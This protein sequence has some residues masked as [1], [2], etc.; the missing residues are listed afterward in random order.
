MEEDIDPQPAIIV[1]DASVVLA[2]LLPDEEQISKLEHYYIQFAANKL[3]FAAP[4]LLKFEVTNA[5]R[6]SV[7]RKRVLEKAATRLL[8]EFLKLPI[9]YQDVSF[10]RALAIALER[11]IS[12]YDAAYVSLAFDL[13][14]PLVSLDKRPTTITES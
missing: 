11:Q 8:K 1:I 6:S 7:L 13:K 5:L 14:V 2:K 9:Y 4:V 12:A 3:D 10:K